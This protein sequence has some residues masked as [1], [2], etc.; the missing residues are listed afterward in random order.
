MDMMKE[1]AKKKGT[2]EMDPKHKD[3]KMKVLKE[4]HKMASDSMG[5]DLH[6]MKKGV[7]VMAPDEAGLQKGLQLA[8][9]VTGAEGEHDAHEADHNAVEPQ[10]EAP[11]A[12]NALA[13]SEH[14]PHPSDAPDDDD[15]S[16]E[17]LEQLI[18]ALQAKKAA[19]AKA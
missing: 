10:H 17:E 7:T 14:S 19:K 8:Q 1:L 4:I 18:A 6:G 15:M 9:A 12:G 16:H 13:M 11:E 5:D 2:Q 3:A